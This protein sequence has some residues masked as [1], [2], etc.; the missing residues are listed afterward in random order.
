MVVNP[1]VMAKILVNVSPKGFPRRARLPTMDAPPARITLHHRKVRFLKEGSKL[2]F[3]SLS[4]AGQDHLTLSS[5]IAKRRWTNREAAFRTEMAS[6]PSVLQRLNLS[7]ER[8]LH[9]AR[10][11][12]TSAYV[13]RR[14]H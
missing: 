8:A 5:S 4:A 14:I 10:P 12:E 11:M 3:G 1:E 13:R 2:P 7:Y 9:F 6:F